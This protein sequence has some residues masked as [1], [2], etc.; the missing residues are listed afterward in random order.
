[1]SEQA[2]HSPP[3]LPRLGERAPDFE[4][5]TTRGRLR[6]SDFAGSWVVLFSHP[7]DFT[8]VCTT[9]FVALAEIADDLRTREVELLGLSIDSLHSHLAWL[10]WIAEQWGREIPFPVIADHDRRV[11]TA[12]GMVHPGD[13]GTETTRCVFVID[14]KAVVRA[15]IYYPLTTGRNTD[16]IVRLIDALQF[17]DAEALATPANWRPGDKALAPAPRTAE[18]MAE[19]RGQGKAPWFVERAGHGRQ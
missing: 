18:D 17:S 19:R 14:D 16:E 6:L 4:A 8:P 7:A 5:E 12:Y 1:V 11:A 15:M 13:S 10:E 3:S 2:P 9:E